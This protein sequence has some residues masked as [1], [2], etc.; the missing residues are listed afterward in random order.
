MNKL[1]KVSAALDTAAQELVRT[2]TRPHIEDMV[3]VLVNI[4]LDE[5]AG[6]RD[7]MSA[8][9]SVIEL[10]TRGNTASDG[11]GSGNTHQ[12]LIVNASDPSAVR[13][14]AEDLKRL[15][16]EREGR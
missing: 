15:R 5:K 7:R 13:E 1:A 12:L 8:A 2:A 10:H 3:R 9:T 4:A 16:A 14:A 11:D 6:K